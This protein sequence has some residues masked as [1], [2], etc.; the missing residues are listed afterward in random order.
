MVH[1]DASIDALIYLLKEYGIR[2][3]VLSSGTR[4][5]PFVS[6]VEVDDEFVCHSIID[7]RNAPFYALGIA[8]QL[9]EPVGIACTSGTAVPNYYSGLTEAFYSKIPL[10]AITFDRSPHVLNQLETQKMDQTSIFKTVTNREVSLPL[11]KDEDDLRCCV[12]LIN[13][14]L[15]DMGRRGR[16]PVHINVPLL[17]DTNALNENADLPVNE[18]LSI[19]KIEYIESQDSSTWGDLAKRLGT[20]RNVLIIAGQNLPDERLSDVVSSFTSLTRSPV[21]MDNLANLRCDEMIMAQP[22]IKALNSNTLGRLC[23]DLVITFGGNFQERIKDI[24]R[25]HRGS[26]DHWSISPDGEIHDVFGC[27]TALFDCEPAIFFERMTSLLS[28]GSQVFS[29]DYLHDW[30]EVEQAALLPE[31]MPFSN[32]SVMRC[33]SDVIPHDSILH[34]SILNSTRIMQFFKLDESITV[35]SNVNAFGI[36]G[37]MPTLMGQAAVTDK[38]AFLVIG[39]LSFFYAMNAL[40]IKGIASNVRVL[41][42]NNGGG[43]EF[44]IQPDSDARP[45][46]DWHIGA[47]HCRVAEGW[48]RSCGFEYY[49]ARNEQELEEGLA[50]L[51]DSE[52]KSPIFVEVFT[53]LSSDGQNCLNVYRELEKHIEPVVRKLSAHAV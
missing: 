36:D 16:G 39:D 19:R 46:I 40:S 7:E 42:I 38:L 28:N 30:Q 2:H 33:F 5:L 45:T 24:L 37:C 53:G 26:F 11:V 23:P 1:A 13:E 51:V 50:R 17:G 52:S 8:Q 43:A 48:A 27:Q 21:L 41:L 22:V 9:H 18:H 3:L 35:T 25:A 29:S 12:R 32:F 6:K 44:H 31:K 34:L 47:A 20:K 49:A 4:N 14:A 10:V 15:I